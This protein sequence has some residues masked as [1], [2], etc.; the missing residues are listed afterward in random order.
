MKLPDMPFSFAPDA[1][2]CLSF[3]ARP[4]RFGYTLFNSA[5]QAEQL[6]WL[7]KPVQ[8][9]TQEQLENAVAGLRGLN[10]RG[11]G[12]S[13]PWKSTIMPLLDS[14]EDAAKNIGAVNTVVN[15]GGT[16]RGHNTDAWGCERVLK[17]AGVTKGTTVLLLG[18]GGVASALAWALNTIGAKTTVAARKPDD[19]AKRFGLAA[20][21]WP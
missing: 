14:I 3:A 11:C 21:K 9:S 17:E 20:V 6:N 8:I 12:V 5:F 10:V 2:L 13:M 1:T 7:Y 15:D 18:A 4:S 19:F 16:L